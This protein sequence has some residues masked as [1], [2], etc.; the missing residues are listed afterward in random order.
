MAKKKVR[1]TKKVNM[2][3]PE[4]SV[5][6]SPVKPPAPSAS[7]PEQEKPKKENVAG[8]TRSKKNATKAEEKINEQDKENEPEDIKSEIIKESEKKTS[9]KRSNSDVK[10][11]NTE[12]KS[13]PGNESEKKVKPETPENVTI[14]IIFSILE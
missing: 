8:R 13:K 4:E 14:L 7:E 5:N 12:T 1:N 11:D 10:E 3:P 2:D 9:K 6:S